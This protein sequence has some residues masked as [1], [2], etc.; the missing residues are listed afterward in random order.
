MLVKDGVMFQP[1]AVQRGQE[2]DRKHHGFNGAGES[3]NTLGLHR[4]VNDT[5]ATSNCPACNC[6]CVCSHMNRTE[7][8]ITGAPSKH[9]DPV[10]PIT[11][12]K[13]LP[14]IIP[15]Q[16]R[17]G[18]AS[19]VVFDTAPRGIK[20]IILASMRTGSSFVGEM[21]GQN[22]NIFYLFEPGRALQNTLVNGALFLHPLYTDMLDNLYQCNTTGYD[23]YIKWISRRHPREI[24]KI[25]PRMY[26]FVCS[27]SNKSAHI[28][29]GRISAER[30]MRT[31]R[32]IRNIA[33]KTI[34]ISDI[35]MLSSLIQDNS[36]NLKVIHLVR[37]PRGMI[38]SRAKAISEPLETFWDETRAALINYCWSNL[39]NKEVGTNL[40]KF[41][42]N[43]LLLRY[44]DVCVDPQEAARR[45]YNFTGLGDVPETVSTWI[46]T[47]TSHEIP[48]TYSTSRVSS[49]AYESWRFGLTYPISKTIEKVGKCAQMMQQFGYLSAENEVHLKNLTLSLVGEVQLASNLQMYEL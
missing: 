13:T 22:S 24:L 10:I 5:A 12:A 44:E 25:A 6:P 15:Q 20:V 30:F 29:C 21:L 46:S 18:S 11:H 36:V 14:P 16:L 3:T 42:D 7:M 19:K 35:G 45:I 4:D 37:D 26:D 40:T 9:S 27:K 32:E 43:Y 23:Y 47:H 39:H 41:R 2:T 31:C 38:A 1:R 33:I 48:G 17:A 49:K 28:K 34:R 8:R